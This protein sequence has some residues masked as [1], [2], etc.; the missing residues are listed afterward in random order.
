MDANQYKVLLDKII[1]NKKEE[2]KNLSL[3]VAAY[4]K[5]DV[6]NALTANKFIA[7]EPVIMF[8]AGAP[9]CGKSETV[10]VILEEFPNSV[11]IDPDQF[12]V[13]FPYYNGENAHDYQKACTGILSHC[14]DKAIKGKFDIIHDTNFAHEETAIRNVSKALKKGY[15]VQ[16]N[17]V[18]LD[19]VSAW[20]HAQNRDRKILPQVFCNN[21]FSV[22]QTIKAVLS[23]PEFQGKEL[24]CRA[25]IYTEIHGQDRFSREI[26][27]NIS[28]DTLD[29]LVP[30]QYSASDLARIAV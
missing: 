9:A 13:L 6:F 7:G 23:H 10:R 29:T 20:K 12:R 5:D 21:F 3:D 17:Y 30:F 19:P 11:H 25:F 26:I 14:F 28:S 22:R 24:L 18:Y 1:S 2:I 15:A 16:I 27:E 4:I 8:T